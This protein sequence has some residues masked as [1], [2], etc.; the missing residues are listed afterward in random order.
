MSDVRVAVGTMRIM[1]LVWLF[2]M[3]SCGK[4]R[5]PRAVG[6]FSQIR[7]EA[8]KLGC[9]FDEHGS[10]DVWI[11]PCNCVIH[12]EVSGDLAPTADGVEQGVKSLTVTEDACYSGHGPDRVLALIE[13][14]F[15]EPER[16]AVRALLAAPPPEVARGEAAS[17][18]GTIGARDVGVSWTPVPLPVEAEDTL[19]NRAYGEQDLFVIILP[20]Y[21]HVEPI[22]PH[23]AF[24]RSQESLQPCK[25]HSKRPWERDTKLP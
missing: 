22:E 23:L 12:V 11:G 19:V 5:P 18:G 21:G 2:A 24:R 4:E 17:L 25:D 10:C 1:G 6:V 9:E 7:A 20:A 14:L 3:P 8:A 13:P 15:P 16:T